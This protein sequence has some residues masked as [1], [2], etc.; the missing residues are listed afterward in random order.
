[1]TPSK[2]LFYFSLASILG[3]AL[4]SWKSVSQ[5][6]IWVFLL[7]GII[8][9]IFFLIK[10]NTRGMVISF[11]LF[12]FV[13]GI[14]RLQIAEFTMANSSLKKHNDAKEKI[15]LQGVI[16]EDPELKDASQKIILRI[17][18]DKVLVMA[19]RYPEYQYLDKIRVAGK[20]KTP[21]QFSDFD[22]QSYLMKDGIYSVMDFPTIT[23]ISHND[24]VG[25]SFL[26]QKILAVKH[27]LG[28]SLEQY[29]NSEE[30]H[31]MQ[32]L[33]FGNDK[34]TPEE[35]KEKFRVT[36][37]SHVTA[38]S[39]GNI[40]I[41]T[42]IFLLIGLAIG[43]WR[44]QALLLSIGGIWFYIML[45]GLPVSAIRAGLM[46]SVFLLAQ[47]FGRQHTSLRMLFLVASLMI[48]QNPW[49][50]FYD[51]SFQLSFLASLGIIYAKPVIDYYL[52]RLAK[53]SF[54]VMIDSISVTLS[55]QLFTL[56]IILYNF[57]RIS[58]VSPMTNVLV[59]PIVPW[60]T[61]LG[62]LVAV[63]GLVHSFLGLIISLPAMLLLEYFL[64]VVNIFYQPWASLT[65]SS[66][67]SFWITGFSLGMLIIFYFLKKKLKDTSLS[68]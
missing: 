57:G 68:F 9:T 51:V 67:F 34:N 32:G 22:Y 1:M 42:E 62:L 55:A 19:S 60:L 14:L 54:A 53:N 24:G 27:A 23:L 61:I 45:I 52:R 13:L 28:K 8:G 21:A 43:C 16:I 6:G 41:L 49:L 30:Q 59:L 29:F 18:S 65:L 64:G 39:G 4:E 25:F 66:A 26:Y 35:M 46:G 33:V 63:L 40:I 31:L 11:C 12:F 47:V 10:N 38:V 17:G 3:V 50:L 36:G 44:W 7:L 2:I 56:P 48:F 15:T 20:L 37:L 58:L 5:I